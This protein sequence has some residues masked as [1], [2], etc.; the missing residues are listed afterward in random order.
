MPTERDDAAPAGGLQVVSR[1]AQILRMFSSDRT[2]VRIND[3]AEELGIGRTSAHRYLQSLASEGFLQRINDNDYRPGPLIMGI[4]ASMLTGPKIIDVA[5]PLLAALAERT[6]QT[7]VLGLWTGSSAVAVASKEPAGKSVN[8]TVRIGA[9]LGPQ[10]AQGL[11]FLAW[12]S[13]SV[14]ERALAKLGAARG[15]VERK[16]AEA[17]AVG[18]AVSEAVIDGVAAVAAPVFDAGGSVIATLA[19]VAPVGVLDTAADGRHIPDLKASAAALSGLLGAST[20]A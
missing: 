10:S 1:S 18:F 11:A 3:V 20:A 4:A 15:E 17:L 19:L 16:L 5:E 8:M 7:A 12:G 2:E 9:P 6:G 14:R 13:P